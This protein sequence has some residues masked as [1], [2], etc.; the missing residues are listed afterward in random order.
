MIGENIKSL[1]KIHDLTQAEFAKINSISRS[2][3]S[4]YENVTSS[5]STELTDRISQ[6]FNISCVDIV[7]KE[8]DVHTNR[9]LPIDTKNRSHQR[10]WRSNFIPIVPLSR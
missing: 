7:G 10:T 5:I 1:R 2:R 4:S 9:R 6:K 8:I 3:L